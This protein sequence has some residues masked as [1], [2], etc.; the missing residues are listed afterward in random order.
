MV[1]FAGS[2]EVTTSHPE[3]IPPV[4]TV[5]HTTLHHVG[6]HDG[7]V[8]YLDGRGV[9]ELPSAN[10]IRYNH[11]I[12]VRYTDDC[13]HVKLIERKP[14]GAEPSRYEGRTS[15]GL[16]D[17]LLGVEFRLQRHSAAAEACRTLEQRQHG[18]P[19]THHVEL[20]GAAIDRMCDLLNAHHEAAGPYCR[21]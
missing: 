16:L 5:V 15:V 14:R 8:L 6:T 21:L 18:E 12:D 4:G 11:L 2:L 17:Y 1:A 19:Y 9:L 13:N 7:Y 10:G 20:N 3:N